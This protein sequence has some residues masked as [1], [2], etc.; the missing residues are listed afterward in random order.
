M[1]LEKML[2]F[3]KGKKMKSITIHNL[4]D[5]LDALIREKAKHQGS[6][7]NKTIKRILKESLGVSEDCSRKADFIEF[8]GTW[9]KKDEAAFRK[10]TQDLEKVDIKDWL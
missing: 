3:R 2:F 1:V 8:S 10:Q 5:S 9:S 6:S 4:D 7:L